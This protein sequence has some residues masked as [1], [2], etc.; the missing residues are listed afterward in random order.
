MDSTQ[1]DSTQV[2]STQVDFNKVSDLSFQEK[3]FKTFLS[4]PVIYFF[5]HFNPT[6]PSPHTYSITL[7]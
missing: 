3:A 7:I 5:Q 4:W 1:V 2:E 6:V